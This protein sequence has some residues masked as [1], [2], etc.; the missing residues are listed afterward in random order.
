MLGI[1]RV[2]LAVKLA[3][4]EILEKSAAHC[5]FAI[6]G[7]D[8]RDGVRNEHTVENRALA[9]RIRTKFLKRIRTSAALIRKE[10]Y[11]QGGAG[12]NEFRPWHS[13]RSVLRNWRHARCTTQN[14][15]HMQRWA[16]GDG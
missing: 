5:A 15:L 13:M 11:K 1:D 2:S 7:A 14:R 3:P 12:G 9:H 6:G 10:L 16:I 4:Q 8:H